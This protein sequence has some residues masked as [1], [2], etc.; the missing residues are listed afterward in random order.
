M[1]EPSGT[2]LPAVQPRV[3]SPLAPVLQRAGNETFQ[4]PAN[5]ASFG[6]AVGQPLP[7]P[8]R[9]KMESFFNTNFA[10][11]RVHGGPQAPSIGALAFT[12]GS[13]L[14]FAPGQYNPTTNQG[15]QLLGH[16]L[17]HVMQQRA[18]RVNN[19]FGA[20]IAVV[21]DRDLEAEADRMGLRAA[22][23]LVPVQARMAASA[24]LAGPT[25]GQLSPKARAIWGSLPPLG[26]GIVQRS[27]SVT[28]SGMTPI[29]K[30]SYQIVAGIGDQ[31]I[32]SVIVH[33]RGRSTIEVTDLVVEPCHRKR[34]LGGVLMAS[35]ARA[36]LQ[37][38]KTRV[39]VASQDNGTGR[40]TSWYKNMG[41]VPTGASK[42]GYPVLE[43]PI[44]RA[45]SA[46]QAR[47]EVRH[48]HAHRRAQRHAASTGSAI[49][50]MREI[51]NTWSSSLFAPLLVT[52]E[53]VEERERRAEQLEQ[54]DQYRLRIMGI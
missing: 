10:E 45:L 26:R 50:R 40:L 34:G 51:P 31:P 35:A 41:F 13:N 16:E 11:V 18:G 1:P 19:P 20:G 28:V 39:T 53:E 44:G 7:E 29:G 25:P 15:Q 3:A 48:A 42:R 21:Q 9:Q 8:V 22:S 17:A 52:R 2:L 24:P 38:G 4:L 32:G 49:Q 14:Y 27:T 23:H 12:H 6:G 37:L 46:V 30:G 54:L 43:A 47:M 5:L 33:D 36:G